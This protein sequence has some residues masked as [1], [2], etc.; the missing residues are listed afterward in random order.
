MIKIYT[1]R[2][3]QTDYNLRMIYQG[4]KLASPLNETGKR[5]AEIAR[6]AFHEIRLDAIISNPLERCISTAGPIASEK[7]LELKVWPETTEIDHG[8]LNG[9]SY[10]HTPD[11]WPSIFDS[12]N[13]RDA[14]TVEQVYTRAEAAK[15]R[16]LREYGNSDNTILMVSG[17]GFIAMLCCSLLGIGRPALIREYLL[18]NL[19]YHY[20]EIDT[21]GTAQVYK[22]NQQ[23]S[24]R[25]C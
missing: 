3:G 18:E 20:F 17:Q 16:L 19:K 21:N 11:I 2:H 12:A 9:T 4:N 5:E 14:E 24:H 7:G 22:L 10:A 8:Y 25:V 13:R 23:L 1:L 6:V 15:A